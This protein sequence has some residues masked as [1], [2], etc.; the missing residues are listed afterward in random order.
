MPAN[1]LLW[2]ALI[3]GSAASAQTMHRGWKVVTDSRHVLADSPSRYW[4]VFRDPAD[5]EDS[6]DTHWYVPFSR[7]GTFAVGELRLEV[8][9][10]NRFQNR[11]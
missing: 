1:I 8:P 3:V 9:T 2:I 6:P 4:Y 10:A 11:S 5:G 7:T